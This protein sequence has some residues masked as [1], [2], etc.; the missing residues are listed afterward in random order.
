M[1]LIPQNEIEE[2]AK[3]YAKQF[4]TSNNIEFKANIGIIKQIIEITL[5][6]LENAFKDIIVENQ[7]LKLNQDKAI[8]FADWI[9]KCD[10]IKEDDKWFYWDGMKK[11]NTKYTTKELFNEF[12]NQPKIK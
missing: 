12:L 6:K 3:K 9:D 7:G 1:K 4:H 11:Y 5:Q 8:E 2:A 10:Y